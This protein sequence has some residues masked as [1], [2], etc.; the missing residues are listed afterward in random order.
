MDNTSIQQ[1]LEFYQHSLQKLTEALPENSKELAKKSS[2]EVVV[3]DIVAMKEF[4][5]VLDK[6]IDIFGHGIRSS[7]G[8]AHPF[9]KPFEPFTPADEMDDRWKMLLVRLQRGTPDVFWTT[10]MMFAHQL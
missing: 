2:E 1:L 4:V 5:D 6:Y 8:I 9:K 7:L 3:E 10:R